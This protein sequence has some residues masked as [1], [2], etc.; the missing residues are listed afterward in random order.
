MAWLCPAPWCLQSAELHTRPQTAVVCSAARGGGAAAREGEQPVSS[1]PVRAQSLSPQLT[2]MCHF[3][4]I[5]GWQQCTAGHRWSWLPRP[6]CI[7][8]PECRDLTLKNHP[9]LQQPAQP[10]PQVRSQW[11]AFTQKLSVAKTQNSL[12]LSHNDA[13]SVCLLKWGSSRKSNFQFITRWPYSER[14]WREASL[15]TE[16]KA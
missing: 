11:F 9:Q 2:K 15:R 16:N 6:R 13:G 5:T 7:S 12:S 4:I 14:G 3:I 1:S 8:A 10:A